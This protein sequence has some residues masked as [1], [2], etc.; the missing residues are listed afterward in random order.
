MQIGNKFMDEFC[1]N[2]IVPA[3]EACDLEAKRVDKHNEGRLLKSEIVR[4]VGE[5]E[6]IVADLTNERPNCYLEIGYAMGIDKFR[7]LAS[8][9]QKS[10][11]FKSPSS[12][13]KEIPVSAVV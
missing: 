4:F 2:A 10:S 5:A 1:K 3:I 7:N 6:I 13:N 8:M 9:R 11:D 12:S